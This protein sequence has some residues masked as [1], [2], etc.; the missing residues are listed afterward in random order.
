MAARESLRARAASWPRRGPGHTAHCC[1]SH[2]Q[3]GL[4]SR[5]L[6]MRVP[7]SCPLGSDS[8]RGVPEARV[9]PW[10]GPAPADVFQGRGVGT[11]GSGL[12][13]ATV[14]LCCLPEGKRAGAASSVL[15]G[16]C[17]PQ[18]CHLPRPLL[19]AEP[20]IPDS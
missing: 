18:L 20:W 2:R 17:H 11:L 4:Q 7:A 14:D 5:V 1:H 8:A 10:P 19:L 3:H 13:L 12:V 16:H 9:W 15:L 6:K